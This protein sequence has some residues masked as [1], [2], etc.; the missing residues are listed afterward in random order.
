MFIATLFRLAKTWKQAKCASIGDWVRK[1]QHILVYIF[2]MCVLVSVTALVG[3]PGS[4]HGP[5]SLLL[6]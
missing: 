3:L 2:E 1:R 5:F 6:N 4:N